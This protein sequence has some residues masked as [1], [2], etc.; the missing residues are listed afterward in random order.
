MPSV[1]LLSA[2][3]L[4]TLI[5][6]Y[7]PGP[8]MLYATAQTLAR[9]R[10]A[11]LRAAIGLH[12]GGY[13]HVLAAAFGLALLFQAVPLLYA[14]LKMAG[15]IYLIYLGLKLIL[16]SVSQAHVQRT[17]QSAAVW[18]SV[19]VEV[20]NPKTALF[21]LAFLPQFTD[22]AA[23]LPIWAQLLILGTFVNFVFSS[24]DVLCV[25]LADRMQR[26]LTRSARTAPLARRTGGAILIALG[27][28]TALHRR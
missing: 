17:E 7:M 28:M 9:G 23:T 12:L 21:Y 27:L 10:R 22:L 26:L 16:Q 19:V 15:A 8:G 25:M 5:F 6:G 2:F 13:V 24:A 11:G 1:D 3:F 4:A 20:L 14:V 18:Q